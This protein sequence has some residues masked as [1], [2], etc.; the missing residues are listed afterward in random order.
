MS[1]TSP[2]MDVSAPTRCLPSLSNWTRRR[3]Y[4]SVVLLLLFTGSAIVAGYARDHVGA[5]LQI[6]TSPRGPRSFPSTKSSRI[7]SHIAILLRRCERPWR[8]TVVCE[9]VSSCPRSSDCAWARRYFLAYAQSG[10]EVGDSRPDNLRG[11]T[12]ISAPTCMERDPLP[13][14]P[15]VLIRGMLKLATC[16]QAWGH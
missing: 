8:K 13:F 10:Q 3:Q 16:R 6:P 14:A 9:V 5:H 1:T 15:S 12:R 11:P 7:R 2:S 4:E